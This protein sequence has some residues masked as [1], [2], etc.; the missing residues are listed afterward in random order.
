DA[1]FAPFVNKI[2]GQQTQKAPVATYVIQISS[3]LPSATIP[4]YARD[5]VTQMRR[6][7]P[8]GPYQLVAM[9]N[10]QEEVIAREMIRQLKDHLVI[11]DVQLLL[12]DD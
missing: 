12:L 5:M 1:S 7:Q 8:R 9:R 6:I 10:K 11:N 2:D 4:T 3:M